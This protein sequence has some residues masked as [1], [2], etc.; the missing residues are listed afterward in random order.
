M[1]V[2]IAFGLS[3][4]GK[5]YFAKWA[6]K[7]FH[8]Y[9]EDADHWLT[10]EMRD[11]IKSGTIFTPEMLDHYFTIVIAHLAEL[12]KLHANI[13][14]SQALY[15]EKNRQQLLAAYPD[16]QFILVS[17]GED[18]VANRL[19]QRGNEV[20]LQYAKDNAIFFEQP[21]HAHF[22]IDNSQDNSD[23]QLALQCREQGIFKNV[24]RRNVFS[25]LFNS[26]M[27]DNIKKNLSCCKPGPK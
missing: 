21:K 23:K 10:D 24:P 7:N 16:I 12:K 11:C 2:Y 6:G 18:V 17:A 5:S 14:I 22:L 15:L 1:A 19:V 20:T 9:E 4:A 27:L 25:R 13:I 8:L 26:P 3:G